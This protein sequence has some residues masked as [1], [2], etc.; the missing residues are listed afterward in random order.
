[1]EFRD[2]AEFPKKLTEAIVRG[3]GRLV[4]D[5]IDP[6]RGNPY[7]DMTSEQRQQI[8]EQDRL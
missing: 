6:F 8:E 3:L 2:L 7:T 1:M 4:A 5:I